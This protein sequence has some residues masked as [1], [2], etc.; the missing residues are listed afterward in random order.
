[1]VI[2]NSVRPCKQKWIVYLCLGS[3]LIAHCSPLK[4]LFPLVVGTTTCN[5]LG[6]PYQ[7]LTIHPNFVWRSQMPSRRLHEASNCRPRLL[8]AGSRQR[9]TTTYNGVTMPISSEKTGFH[10]LT[11]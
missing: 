9:E 10:E 2:V 4:K 7:S 3:T 6:V 5:I 1:M 11:V 8:M